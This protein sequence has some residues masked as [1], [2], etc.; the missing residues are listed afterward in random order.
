MVHA[1]KE[2]VSYEHIVNI[3][4]HRNAY[5]ANVLLL[6]LS[7]LVTQNYLQYSNDVTTEQCFRY[8]YGTCWCKNS[9]FPKMHHYVGLSQMGSDL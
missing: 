2:Y 4:R 5:N 9:G 8:V 6:L 7:S 3:N 1:I